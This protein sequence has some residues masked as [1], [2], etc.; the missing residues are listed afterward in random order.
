MNDRKF[1]LGRRWSRRDIVKA[2]SGAAALPLVMPTRSF[3]KPDQLAVATGGGM[4]EDAYKK[5]VFK[6][7]QERT[8]IPIVTTANEASRLKAMVEQRQVEWDVVQGAGEQYILFGRQGLFEPID[9]SIVDKSKLL[10]HVAY[11]YFVLTDIAAYHIA[12]NTQKVKSKP[13]QT[14]RE[15]WDYPGRIGLHKEPGQTLEIALL[16]D[17]VSRDKLYPLDVARALHSLAR[18][19]DKVV[20]WT[21]GAQGAQLLISGEVDVSAIWNGRVYQPKLQG[22]PVDYH[23]NQ[24]IFVSDAWAVPKGAPNRKESM[25]LIAQELSAP[26]QAA[27]ARLLP[28]GPVNR[29][30][31]A[32]LSPEV[33]AVLPSSPANF[34]KGTMLNL[35]YWADNGQN[36]ADHFNNWLLG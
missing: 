8:G 23:F 2:L 24:A 27:F 33:Q 17:G 28:Y 10:P 29:D 26:T 14:W 13:P 3:A 11:P 21:S 18:I 36:V 19:K 12:W 15:V 22:A 34:G 4:L 1:A 20:W 30:A 32:M 5:T 16:A 35:E 7:W 9:Y 25:Q 6:T 31:M